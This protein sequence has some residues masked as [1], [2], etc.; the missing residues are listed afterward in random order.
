LWR[1]CAKAIA[2][3]NHGPCC[4]LAMFCT[5]VWC[6]RAQQLVWQ[7]VLTVSVI[8]HV[9]CAAARCQWAAATKVYCQPAQHLL[10]LVGAAPPPLRAAGMATSARAT[11]QPV[12]S[13]P[14]F[15]KV[16]FEPEGLPTLGVSG[17]A[18]TSWE[19]DLLAVAVTEDD[20]SSSGAVQCGVHTL[21]HIW[22]MGSMYAHHVHTAY[23]VYRPPKPFFT[24]THAWSPVG[25][26]HMHTCR[27][28]NTWIREDCV[29]RECTS[30]S[31]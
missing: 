26:A 17:A 11:A 18:L 2:H 21:T 24:S 15:D 12:A 3:P 28:R 19:G 5:G 6:S 22:H 25:V 8:V 16:A 31:A 27:R 20:L 14:G 23:M 29:H 30:G 4:A 10:T 7:P 13:V 9:R 1:S